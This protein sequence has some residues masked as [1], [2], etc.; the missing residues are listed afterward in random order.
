VPKPGTKAEDCLIILR[1]EKVGRDDRLSLFRAA[2]V[3]LDTSV[4]AGLNLMPFEFITAHHDNDRPVVTLIS[5]FSGC[6]S[7]LLGSIRINPWNTAEVVSAC[8]RAIEMDFADKQEMHQLNLDY[9][10]GSCP[11]ECF[12][13]SLQICG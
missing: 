2:D 4:K 10:S 11:F 3:M 12:K 13:T 5:E 6:S 9:V 7:V 8:K 1:I